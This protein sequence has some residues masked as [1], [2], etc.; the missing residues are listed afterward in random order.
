MA[1][2]TMWANAKGPKPGSDRAISQRKAISE[3]Y[4]AA[5]SPC[6][7]DRNQPKTTTGKNE[8]PGLTTRAQRMGAR[9]R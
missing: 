4:Q 1:T 8:A 7:I 3:G 9:T 6:K 2:G 5:K